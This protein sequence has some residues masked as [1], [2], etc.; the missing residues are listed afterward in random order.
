MIGRG[1]RIGLRGGWDSRPLAGLC[2]AAGLS[3]ADKFHRDL[4]AEARAQGFSWPAIG[5]A[6]WER[7]AGQE[8]PAVLGNAG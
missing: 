1:E 5:Q 8:S 4:V 3:T 6:A 2:D 7:L